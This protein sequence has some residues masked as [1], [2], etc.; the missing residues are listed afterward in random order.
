MLRSD[1][2][3]LVNFTADWC[4]PCRK[5]KPLLAELREEFGDRLR[6]VELDTDANPAASRDYGVLS[7]PTLLLFS[8]GEPVRSIVGLQ[9]KRKL[10]EWISEGLGA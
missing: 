7:A 3:V 2:P 9:P 8:G 1:V 5:L 4:P 10:V 6:I